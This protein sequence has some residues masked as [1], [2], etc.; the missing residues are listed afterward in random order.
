MKSKKSLILEIGS[1]YIKVCGITGGKGKPRLNSFDVTE[2]KDELTSQ[3][4]EE[5]LSK[6]AKKKYARLVVSLPRSFFLIKFISLPSENKEEIEKMFYFQLPKILPYSVDEVIYDFVVAGGKEGFSKIVVFIIQKKKIK[7]LLE[8]FSKNKIAP[9][10]VTISSQGLEDWYSYQSKKLKKPDDAKPVMLVDMDKPSAEFLVIDRDKMVFSRSFSGATSQEFVSGVSQSLK[11][12]ER[13]FGKKSFSRVIFTGNHHPALMERVQVAS[14][15]YK[16]STEKFVVDKKIS[17]TISE[18]GYS[19][20][21]VLGLA[22]Q[23]SDKRLDFSFDF[24]Q[25]RRRDLEKRNKFAG[26]A[27]VG[28][29]IILIC[30]LF[31]FKYV[32]EKYQHLEYLNSKLSKVKVEAEELEEVTDKLKIINSEFSSQGLLSEFLYNIILPMPQSTKLTLLDFDRSGDFYL[33][34]YTG[35]MSDVFDIVSSLNKNNAFEDAKIKSASKAKENNRPV[36]KFY[37]YGKTRG[38]R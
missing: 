7:H 23:K 16:N 8:F 10:I 17:K 30:G 28:I 3:D 22:L 38:V 6:C 4:L 27:V 33:K 31:L 5:A 12:F 25:K 37:I 19:V 34:G 29:E 15:E 36:I 32:F 11:I 21:S 9:D 2:Y 35:Q 14:T 1:K 13:E 18:K 20:A 24:L 26:Y